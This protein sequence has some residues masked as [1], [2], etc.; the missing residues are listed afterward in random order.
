[1]IQHLRIRWMF[2]HRFCNKS[3]KTG[4]TSGTGTAYLPEQLCSLP[5]FSGF[6][7]TRSLAT[8]VCFVDGCFCSFVVFHSALCC[9]FFFDI[10]VLITPLVSSN[11]SW[12]LLSVLCTIPWFLSYISLLLWLPAGG[13]LC[14]FP[15]LLVYHLV[16][17]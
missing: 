16:A 17:L 10:R 1:M 9:L 4:A 12:L 11:S 8:F 6:R 15:F 5:I 14:P 3:N 7:V 2:Y 13:P